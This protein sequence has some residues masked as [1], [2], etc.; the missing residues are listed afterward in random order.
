VRR[1]VESS[2]DDCGGTLSFNR[3]EK[4]RH[5]WISVGIAPETIA[6]RAARREMERG[7]SPS[8]L[9]GDREPSKTGLPPVFECLRNSTD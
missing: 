9:I 3:I 1:L 2:W 6:L 4:N 7:V 8:R 5:S